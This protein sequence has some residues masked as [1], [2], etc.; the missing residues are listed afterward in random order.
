[1]VLLNPRSASHRRLCALL[2]VTMA[3]CPASSTYAQA[4]R[5]DV[6]N[7]KLKYVVPGASAIVVVRPKQVFTAEV[8]RMMPL[9]VIQAVGMKELGIDPLEIEQLVVSA[10]PPLQ[11]PPTYAVHGTFSQA[12]EIKEGQITKHTAPGELQGRRYLKS[13]HPLLPSF[14]AP[15]GTSLLAAPEPAIANMVGGELAKNSLASQAEVAADGHDLYAQIN[16]EALQP[17]IGMAVSQVPAD[18]PAEARPLLGIPRLVKS[19]MLTVNVSNP[20]VSKLVITANNEADASQVENI[21]EEMKDVALA[22][23]TTAAEQDRQIQELL[24][25]DDPVQQAM[26]RYTQRLQGEMKRSIRK[27][28]FDRNG[29][30]FKLFEIDPTRAGQHQ[31]TAIAV[32]GVLVALLLPAVQAAREA[33]R[34]NA[35]MNNIK[36]ILLALHNHHDAR[37]TFPAHANYSDVDVGKPLLSWRVHILPF[38]GEQTLYEQFHL[39]EPWDSAHNK[40]LIPQMPAIYFDPSSPLEINKGRT[41]FLGVEGVDMLFDGSDEPRSIREIRD[42]TSR[43]MAVVQVSDDGA[44]IWTKPDDWQWDSDNPTQV[45]GGLHP[46]IFLAGFCDGSVRAVA[47]DIDPSVLKASLTI[48]GEEDVAIT[49]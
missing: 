10:S 7:G 47:M 34:R 19:V 15:D 29:L 5:A 40:T 32:V 20:T 4:P 17:L 21:L 46:G 18:F 44:A 2:V 3:I 28:Q 24:N 48:A 6:A 39:D 13:L 16:L 8:M 42:G 27:L 41:H 25:S 12:Y 14:F 45:L 43:T 35:A 31:L 30:Q 11:G 33:A 36:M 22:A 38:L 9:E 49:R 1:M 23:M 26:G 37:G